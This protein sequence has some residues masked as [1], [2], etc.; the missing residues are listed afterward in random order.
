MT[1][2]ERFEDFERDEGSN[3]L[4]WALTFLLIGLGIG[5]VT[6]LLLTPKTGP[7]VRRIL[8]RKYEDARERVDDFQDRAGDWVDRGG[9]WA[10][11]ARSKVAT[12]SK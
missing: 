11:Q 3:A 5:A 12:F 9:K 10:K 7:Q 4:P 8:R 6:A 2:F 1:D